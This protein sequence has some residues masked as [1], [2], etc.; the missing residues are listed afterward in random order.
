MGTYKVVITDREYETIDHERRILKEIDADLYDYQVKDAEDIIRVA[1][2]CDAMIV[3]YAKITKEVIGQLDKCKIIARYAT[4]YDGI[5]IKAATDRG[6]F[7]T[8]V[9]DYCSQ[10]VS[11]HALALLM[12]LV[13]KTGRFDRWTREGKWGYQCGLPFSGLKEQIVGVIGFGKIA[14]AYIEKVKPL[15][16]EIW[17]YDKFVPPEVMVNSG[18]RPK[19]FEELICGA[20]YISLHAPLTDDTYHMFN[21][22]T[23]KIMK[24]TAGL[25][26]VAR[27]GLICEEHLINALRQKEI[28]CAA[29]DVL[30]TEPIAS[31]NPLLD[32]ENVVLTPHIG[33]YSKKSQEILQST[34]AKE[35]VRALRGQIPRNLVNKVLDR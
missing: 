8:N 24:P 31:D 5:D 1:K 17:A 16:K 30:E 28:G 21:K 11:T 27:G 10:E 29:L 35:V 4:G 26:N 7:V 14:Q 9:N 20:D 12:E 25:I 32:M 6:I 3:Q 19:S 18:V 33:W 15:C 34:P 23:F 2:D 13:Q 22:D